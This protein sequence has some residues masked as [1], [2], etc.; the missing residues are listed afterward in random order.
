LDYCVVGKEEAIKREILK[1]GPVVAN[2]KIYKDF[3]IY[4]SGVFKVTDG[5]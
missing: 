1:N 2:M 5:I 4:K 3:L